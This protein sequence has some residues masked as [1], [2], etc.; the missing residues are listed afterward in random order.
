MPK[1][2][3]LGQ[4]RDPS[5]PHG[6]ARSGLSQLPSPAWGPLASTGCLQGTQ[7]LDISAPATA[8]LPP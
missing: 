4:R 3:G 2:E 1:P 5:W 7:V 6:L 8:V